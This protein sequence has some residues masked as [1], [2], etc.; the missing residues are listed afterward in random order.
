M[1]VRLE[2]E[3]QF[4]L[5]SGLHTTGDRAELWTDKALVL[6]WHT[7]RR[8]IVP[9]TSIKGWLREGAERVLRAMGK[10]V[11]DG[12][13]PSSICGHCVVC[14][15]FGHPRGRARL[16]FED[17][18]FES[19]SR[20]TRTGVSLS[21]YRKTA[22]EERLFTTEIVWGQSLTVK[23][24]GFFATPDEAKKAAALLWLAAK[25]GFALG[26]GR[27]RGL[28]WLELKKFSARFN[29]QE[30]TDEEIKS[31]SEELAR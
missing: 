22:Y 16:F 25:A 9:A 11:C 18:K 10:D 2:F 3:L 7:G 24:K 4:D 27:S 14:E 5:V 28:G 20:D 30:V 29:G 8:P 12:S 15:I 1:A 31:I 21:R 23:G 19:E 13:Q 26:G 17:G 6:D